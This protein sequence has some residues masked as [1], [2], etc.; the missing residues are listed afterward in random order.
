MNWGGMRTPSRWLPVLQ[1]NHEGK[2]G[3]SAPGLRG[4]PSRGLGECPFGGQLWRENER[5]AMSEKVSERT[6]M[7]LGGE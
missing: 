6:K 7:S 5:E 3:V 4:A 2:E 1:T